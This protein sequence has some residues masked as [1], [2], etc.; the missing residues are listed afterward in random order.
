MSYKTFAIFSTILLIIAAIT[1]YVNL[2]LRFVS[3]DG[4]GYYS[5]LPA[6]VIK[7][8]LS[9][10]TYIENEA[11]NRGDTLPVV[12]QC[13]KKQPLCNE[14]IGFK[15]QENGNWYNKYPIGTAILISPFFLASDIYVQLAG[16]IR[17]GYSMPYQISVVIASIFYAQ[18]GLA[19]T[20]MV[21]KHRF[22]KT[23][24]LL[25]M[26]CLLL[27]TNLIHY[28]VY[29][30]AMSH[31]YSFSLISL[32]IL[33]LDKY[34]LNPKFNLIILMGVTI[35]LIILVR[36]L[37]AVFAIVP[38]FLIIKNEPSNFRLKLFLK[39]CFSWG[40]ILSF[41]LIPQ[42]VYWK[43]SLGQFLAYS[44]GQESFIYINNPQFLKV[45]FDIKSNGVF[46]WHPI[47]MFVIPGIYYMLKEKNREGLII[48]I[49][50]LLLLFIYSSWWAYPF[51]Y[52][53]GY[54]AFTDYYLL[55]LI[56]IGFLFKKISTIK[57][58]GKI[59]FTLLVCLILILNLI[60]LRNYWG[61]I[62]SSF[63]L[64]TESFWNNFA[65]PNIE[66][67]YKR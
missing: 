30:P 50:L 15:P 42:I 63:N 43:I 38:I 33:L 32:T 9:F 10:K 47:L 54:R 17:D 51:G 58:A 16:G 37:N 67:F 34:I 12:E 2:Q 14:Y 7:Q 39:I 1:L 60:H 64:T 29:E 62:V 26:T 57:K 21:L 13:D 19:F 11:V 3:S 61:G 5:Y 48:I 27:G 44:Y 52:A 20:Y 18:L 49:I 35:S 66:K 59:L 25:I 65:N 46:I 45:L 55:F 8:D 41:I 28:T 40:L 23:I 56:P 53:F 4:I 31:V 22:S 6:A 24:S 36:N